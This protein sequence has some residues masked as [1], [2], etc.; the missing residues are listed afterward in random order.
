MKRARVTVDTNAND[1]FTTDGVNI[2]L[3]CGGHIIVIADNRL[4][5]RAML[6]DCVRSKLNRPVGRPV[7]WE[8]TDAFPIVC[9]T[10]NVNDAF[11]SLDL[12]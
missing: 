1:V 2:R 7:G 11:A 6:S 10:H 9:L 8:R 4:E 12:R 5:F 3:N